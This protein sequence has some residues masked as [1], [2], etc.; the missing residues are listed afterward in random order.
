MPDFDTAAKSWIASRASKDTRAAYTRDLDLWLKF[1]SNLKSKPESPSA[2]TVVQFRN[3]LQETRA[4]STM[5]RVLACL[6]ACYSHAWPQI[7][8]PFD[9]KRLPRPP[10]MTFAKTELVS[11]EDARAVI[12]AAASH[13]DSPLRDVALLRVLWSTG[14]R[15]VSAVSI[16][17]DGVVYRDGT[18]WLRHT[19]KGGRPHEID[20]PADTAHAINAWLEVAPVSRWLF[21]VLDGSRAMSVDAVT[22]TIDRAAKVA[23]VHVHPH[24]FRAAFITRGLDAHIA[25]ERMAKAVGHLD[26]RSTA[27]YDR[28]E[29]GAGVV[30]EVAAFRN[31]RDSTD[32]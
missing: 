19:L 21:C 7:D 1:C 9:A 25:I 23:G 18:M 32:H 4:V 15:R 30:S 31:K 11:D 12:D 28:G 20:A 6:S 5:R 24:Q 8:N 13:G 10:G 2:D 27:R 3:W 26:L 14:M 22:K 29:R 16:R 17:R